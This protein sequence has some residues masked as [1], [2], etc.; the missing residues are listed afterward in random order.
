M[1]VYIGIC[2]EKSVMDKDADMDTLAFL[3]ASCIKPFI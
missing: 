2:G 1:L 3:I